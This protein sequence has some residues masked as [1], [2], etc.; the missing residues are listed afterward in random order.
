MS[1][2]EWVNSYVTDN[3]I[4][5]VYNAD[6]KD[7]VSEH[8]KCGGFPADSIETVSH[9]IGP[10]W[11]ETERVKA[12]VTNL[13]STADYGSSV[14]S[15]DLLGVRPSGNPIDQSGMVSMMS[16]DV[17]MEVNEVWSFDDIRFLANHTACVVIAK[18]HQKFTYKG[19]P[20]DDVATNTIVLEKEGSEWKVVR[21]QRSTGVDPSKA[22]NPRQEGL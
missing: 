19:Q 17:Q 6:N 14:V 5:C 1:G 8:A 21:W 18:S 12:V 13:L 16:G 15:S 10:S 9:V 2:I 3:K 22:A 7:L 4:Y 11:G 20:N